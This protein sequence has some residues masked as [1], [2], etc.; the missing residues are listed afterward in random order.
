MED[1]ISLAVAFFLS[2]SHIGK[3]MDFF[4]ALSLALKW[5]LNRFSLP[6]KQHYDGF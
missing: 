4:H 5:L 2:K 3:S 6:L 1:E